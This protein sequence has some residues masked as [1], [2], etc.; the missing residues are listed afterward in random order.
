MRESH[1][2]YWT[3]TGALLGYGAVGM[4]SNGFPFLFVGVGLVLYGLMRRWF[5]GIWSFLVGF[6][7][8]P[9]IILALA[10]ITAPAACGQGKARVATHAT[11]GLPACGAALTVYW[12]LALAFA[13]LALTGALIG[14]WRAHLRRLLRGAVALYTRFP[15]SRAS[16]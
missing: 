9:A 15:R 14:P 5:G 2:F 8:V 4:L 10:S 1:L 16:A 13:A 7:V 12:L 11:G 3:T 6:G